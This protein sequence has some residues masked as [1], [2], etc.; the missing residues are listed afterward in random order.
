MT[1]RGGQ[2]FGETEELRNGRKTTRDE[3]TG[4]AEE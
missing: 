2:G 3:I 4:G 1:A